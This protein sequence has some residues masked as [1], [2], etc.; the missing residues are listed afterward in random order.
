[1]NITFFEALMDEITELKILLLAQERARTFKPEEAISHE[2]MLKLFPER[3][4]S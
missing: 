3:D 1:M 4:T 2:D